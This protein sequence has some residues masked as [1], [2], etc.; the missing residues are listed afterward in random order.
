MKIK[1]M[2]LNY[3]SDLILRFF[4]K[5]THELHLFEHQITFF[6]KCLE[7]AQEF[8]RRTS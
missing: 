4:L 8:A 6:Y 5:I 3:G 1:T 7:V 2:R